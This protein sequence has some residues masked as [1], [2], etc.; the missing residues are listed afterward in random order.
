MASSVLGRNARQG[1][2]KGVQTALKELIREVRAHL[3]P[4]DVKA[5]DAEMLVVMLKGLVHQHIKAKLN[6]R[7][8][9]LW[10]PPTGTTSFHIF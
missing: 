1:P 5:G 2:L 8:L 7:M 10:Q 6:T 3:D 9:I 4:T